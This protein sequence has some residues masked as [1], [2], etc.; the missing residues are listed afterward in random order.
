MKVITVNDVKIQSEKVLYAVKQY[1]DKVSQYPNFDENQLLKVYCDSDMD[2]CCFDSINYR[3]GFKSTE[4]RISEIIYSPFDV[5]K[6]TFT[7]FREH[8]SAM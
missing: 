4:H 6:C 7:E 3:I 1:C 8:I 5:Q 2:F